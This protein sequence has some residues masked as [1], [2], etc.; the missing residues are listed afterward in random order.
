MEFN[1]FVGIYQPNGG[2][3]ERSEGEGA[4]KTSIDNHIRPIPANEVRRTSCAGHGA[5]LSGESPLLADS[6][7]STSLGKGVH[8]EMESEGSRRQNKVVTH[9][10]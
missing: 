7:W 10:N 5:D 1:K 6:N 8:R 3:P 9:R 2:V 4:C